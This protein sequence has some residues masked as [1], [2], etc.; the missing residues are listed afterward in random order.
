MLERVTGFNK[1]PVNTGALDAIVPHL[2]YFTFVVRKGIF[3]NALSIHL[4]FY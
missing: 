4:E 2:T 1:I 3:I